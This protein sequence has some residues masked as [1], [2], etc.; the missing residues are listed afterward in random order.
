MPELPQLPL[1]YALPPGPNPL[2]SVDEVVE[3]VHEAI[4]NHYHNILRDFESID[5]AKLGSVTP[6]DLKE[7]LARH[8]MRMSSEQV[9]VVFILIALIMAIFFSCIKMSINLLQDKNKYVTN[10]SYNS[11][12]TNKVLLKDLAVYR[13]RADSNCLLLFNFL[14]RPMRWNGMKFVTN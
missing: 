11:S 3:R 8:V 10:I 4:V 14:L 7:V 1:D 6:E 13:V 2:T 12:I 9:G 5:Y